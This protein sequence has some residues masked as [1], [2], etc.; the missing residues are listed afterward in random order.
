MGVAHG[1]DIHLDDELVLVSVEWLWL[2]ALHICI[3]FQIVPFVL[4]L[5]L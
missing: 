4:F 3:L 2:L 5:A 1:M